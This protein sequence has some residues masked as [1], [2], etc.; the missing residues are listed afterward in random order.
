MKQIVCPNV[1]TKYSTL[2]SEILNT[3]RQVPRKQIMCITFVLFSKDVSFS[4][5]FDKIIN[6][7]KL[8]IIDVK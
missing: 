3:P 6:K 7:I 2:M 8:I 4:F 1:A 5:T